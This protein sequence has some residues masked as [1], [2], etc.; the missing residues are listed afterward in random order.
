MSFTDCER[1]KAYSQSVTQH[2]R[3]WQIQ[4]PIK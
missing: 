4:K 1:A 3:L 2:L